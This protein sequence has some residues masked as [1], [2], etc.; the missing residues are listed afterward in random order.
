MRLRGVITDKL[1]KLLSKD[2]PAWTPQRDATP[3]KKHKNPKGVE[4][5]QLRRTP[6]P[7]RWQEEVTGHGRRACSAH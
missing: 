6:R 1:L 4:G 2:D 5:H 3:A 7:R